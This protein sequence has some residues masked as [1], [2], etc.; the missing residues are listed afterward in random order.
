MSEHDDLLTAAASLD[1]LGILL[2]LERQGDREARRELYRRACDELAAGSA[3]TIRITREGEDL[4]LRDPDARAP[5]TAT[6]KDRRLLDW[7]VA[8]LA[9]R[10]ED[11]PGNGGRPARDDENLLLAVRIASLMKINGMTEAEAIKAVSAASG[12][13]IPTLERVFDD[14]RQAAYAVIAH[15]IPKPTRENPP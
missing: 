3:H 5:V 11:L 10:I 4:T 13:K 1:P 7:L 8:E 2:E 14:Y 12:K 15:R 9:H 6:L